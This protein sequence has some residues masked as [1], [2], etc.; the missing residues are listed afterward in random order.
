MDRTMNLGQRGYIYL[1]FALICSETHD[2]EKCLT[3]S[4]A[5]NEPLFELVVVLR[6]GSR[7]VVVGGSN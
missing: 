2:P 6:A 7:R 4:Y 1:D 5:K 3:N